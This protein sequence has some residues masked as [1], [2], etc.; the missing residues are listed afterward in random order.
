MR[1]VTVST[2]KFIDDRGIELIEGATV[3]VSDGELFAAGV[4]K[5]RERMWVAT[6]L[7]WESP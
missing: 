6:A 4:L 3:R 7:K 5:Y 1:L 2:L